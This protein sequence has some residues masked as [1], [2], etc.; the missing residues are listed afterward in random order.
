[1]SHE[2]GAAVDSING[3]HSAVQHKEKATMQYDNTV[4]MQEKQPE[5]LTSDA[6]AIVNRLSK[7][8]SHLIDLNDKLHGSKP[9]PASM[10]EA[11]AKIE[12]PPTL[13]RNIDRA[14]AFLSQV[15]DELQHID[16]RV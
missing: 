15:E 9:R 5:L 8:H 16:A 1:L 7:V 14:L 11:T 4:T 13:R 6:A 10:G 3:H 12:P 2:S